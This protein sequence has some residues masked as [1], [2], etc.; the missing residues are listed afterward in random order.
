MNPSIKRYGEY[1]AQK[2]SNSRHLTLLIENHCN[3][4]YQRL[5]H[6]QTPKL[7]RIYT[8]GP[9]MLY[10]IDNSWKV[11]P[12]S[13]S[14]APIAT[15]LRFVLPSSSVAGAQQSEPQSRRQALSSLRQLLLLHL[16]L[17][18]FFRRWCWISCCLNSARSP[19]R[20]YKNSPWLSTSVSSW[21]SC[22]KKSRVG[23]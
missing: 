7:E 23:Y 19:T 14:T 17:T 8:M 18:T 21:P 3:R 5:T 6:H 20:K 2:W 22:K 15:R 16:T 9:C 12:I 13:T 11:A 4:L 10:S 1:S